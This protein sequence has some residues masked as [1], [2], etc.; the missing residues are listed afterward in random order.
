[1]QST[2]STNTNLSTTT[3]PN[4][5]IAGYSNASGIF[6]LNLAVQSVFGSNVG[7]Q[8]YAV[9]TLVEFGSTDIVNYTVY[10][11]APT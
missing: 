8:W 1:L 11:Y 5:V 7:G 9:V 3:Y 2:S 6:G 4:F 10:Y